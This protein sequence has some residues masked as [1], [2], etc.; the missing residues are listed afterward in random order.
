MRTFILMF[1][2][3][4][5]I[6]CYQNVGPQGNVVG[7][8]GDG[9]TGY[10]KISKYEVRGK[11]VPITSAPN[12]FF[13]K[14]A[15]RRMDHDSIKTPFYKQGTSFDVFLFYNSNGDSTSRYLGVLHDYSQHKKTK[16]SAFF[17]RMDE[18]SGFLAVIDQDITAGL[19]TKIRLSGILKSTTYKVELDSLRYFYEPTGKFD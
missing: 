3:N 5:M 7:N 4:L 17:Y 16:Q 1:Y 14:T 8:G 18:T 19:T 15:M 9:L 12:M 13:L 11:S 10:W 2:I 6:G